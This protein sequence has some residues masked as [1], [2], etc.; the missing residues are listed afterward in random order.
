MAFLLCLF[1]GFFIGIVNGILFNDVRVAL[2]GT[3]LMSVVGEVLVT[4]L[5]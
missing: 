2:L 5:S 1:L 3:V 4:S